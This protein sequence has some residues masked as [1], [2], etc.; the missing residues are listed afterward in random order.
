[1]NA[2]KKLDFYSVSY[3]VFK[4]SSQMDTLHLNLDSNILLKYDLY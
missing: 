4:I 3:N 2:S 1:M